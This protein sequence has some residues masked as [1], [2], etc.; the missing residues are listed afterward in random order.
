M[1]CVSCATVRLWPAVFSAGTAGST[2]PRPRKPWHWTHANWTN[3]CAPAA[4][5]RRDLRLPDRRRARAGALRRDRLRS[6]AVVA[7]RIGDDADGDRDGDSGGDDRRQDAHLAPGA[8]LV[9][10]W[11]ILLFRPPTAIRTSPRTSLV[12]STGAARP[13]PLGHPHRR[14][15][16]AR[17]RTRAAASRAGPRDGRRGRRRRRRC[18]FHS[19]ESRSRRSPHGPPARRS[20]SS[21]QRCRS[22]TCWATRDGSRSRR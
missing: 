11:R 20:W 21:R 18:A 7:R 22:P 2:P 17:R 13:P 14:G 9:R 8:L 3:V 4:T 5:G 16:G 6:L 10:H 19:T 15:L 12:E 1:M